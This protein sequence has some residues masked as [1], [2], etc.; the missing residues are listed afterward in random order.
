M[1]KHLLSSIKHGTYVGF[2]N[3]QCYNVHNIHFFSYKANFSVTL[4]NINTGFD[5]KG[6]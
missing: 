2:V 4:E 3:R 5:T 1:E 6:N